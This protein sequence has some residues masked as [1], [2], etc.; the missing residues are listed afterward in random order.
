MSTVSRESTLEVNQKQ[1]EFYNNPG[2][3]K[4]RI[5]R[6]WSYAR[7]KLLSDFRSDSGIKERVY[8]EHKRW[9]GDLSGKKVLDL[10][11]L[12]GNALSIYMAQRC[13]E[14]VGIDLSET[15]IETLNRKLQK[16]NCGNA[17]A[18]AVDFYSDA[19]REKNFDI[20]Y[21]YG[22]VHHFPDLEQLFARMDE[23]MSPDGKIITYDP[24][25]TSLPVKTLRTLYRPFQ[26]DKDW[27]WPF[28]KKALLKINNH[29]KIVSMH[30]ILGSSKWSIP[31]KLL[32][33]PGK[34]NFIS[35]MVD[36]D[37]SIDQIDKRLL[38]CMQV[39]MLLT[40]K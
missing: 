13:S 35:K 32:P 33:F 25:E 22:V 10:G 4:N 1:R 6:V 11:C 3:K 37:W 27:E 2:R 28:D 20:I 23:V 40:K 36:R 8:E 17:R 19:F 18:I 26:S 38:S 34:K 16:N 29:Y 5:T 30:G 31:L 14:Y 7:N 21:A 9:L 24:M 39:T 12:R 15:A